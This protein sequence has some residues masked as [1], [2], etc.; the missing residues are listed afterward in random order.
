MFN[1]YC[2]RIESIFEGLVV[3]ITE[4]SPQMSSP[5]CKCIRYSLQGLCDLSRVVMPSSRVNVDGGG[6]G[7]VLFN[8]VIAFDIPLSCYH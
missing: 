8:S 6:S 1:P 3:S 5:Y 4:L 2:K 7:V